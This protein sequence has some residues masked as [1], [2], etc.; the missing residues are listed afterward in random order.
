MAITRVDF[1]KDNL[2]EG[3]EQGSLR[4]V[5]APDARGLYI[6]S[7]VSNDTNVLVSRDA[8]NNLTFT[9]ALVGTK[10]LTQLAAAASGIGY[11]EFLL[12]NEPTAETGAGSDSAYAATYTG[13]KLTAESWKRVDLTTIKTVVYTYASNRLSTEVI[14]V[15]GLDGTTI[16][17]QLTATYV[18]T[19]NLL[20]SVTTVRDV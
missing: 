16:V 2:T 13:S 17:A 19:S 11:D 8:S 15:F 4:N 14:K 20:T 1:A 18:Y 5:D 9:D 12:R 6:Q 7:D 3:Y 10:T